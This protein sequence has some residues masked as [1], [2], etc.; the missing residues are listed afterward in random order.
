MAQSHDYWD[1]YE[2]L[3]IETPEMLELR[4][5]LAGFGPRALAWLLDNIIIGFVLAL[6]F[7]VVFL[8][9]LAVAPAGSLSSIG[10]MAL[11]FVIILVLALV[12]PTLYYVGFETFWNGQ[13]PGK[14]WLG[15]RVVRRGGLPL[16][17]GQVVTRNLLRLVDQLPSNGIVGLFS[18]FATRYQQR[19]GDLAADTVVIREFQPG[20]QPY[21]WAG[22]PEAL[23]LRPQLPGSLTPA[24]AYTAGSYLHRAATL[25]N[26]S[27]LQ[28]TDELI[29]RLGYSAATLSLRERDEY[30]A[31]L[32][33]QSSN[34]GA[35]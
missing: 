10:S 31:S 2:V 19:I 34:S 32:L 7:L 11:L 17:A 5:P 28:I 21:L 15:I 33:Y 1:D 24:L 14:R 23:A 26:Y 4:L 6:V 12:L 27:R 13:T 22:T 18:F 3:S 29:R 20:R 16:G 9:V 8:A 25:D 35:R 30:L